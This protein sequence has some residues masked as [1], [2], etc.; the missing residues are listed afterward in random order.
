MS[1]PDDDNVKGSII[2][3]VDLGLQFNEA[4]P[5][6]GEDYETDLQG[7]FT[8]HIDNWS[9]LTADKCISPRFKIGDFDWDILLFPQGNHNKC[10]AVYVEPHPE[11]KSD[12]NIDSDEEDIK[13][14]NT[15]SE[16]V[17]NPNWYACAQFAV[18]ISKPGNDK[19]SH[20]ISRS[21]HR[22]NSADTD[23]GFS[24]LIDLYYLKNT[25]RGRPSGFI[26]DNDLNVTIFV[27]ILKDPTGV[28]WH[29]F[30]NYDSKKETG[31]VG[32]RNQGATCYLN[33]LL[34]SYFFTKYFR[35]L[36]YDIPTNDET[37]NDSVALALQRAFYQ[38]QVSN[39]PLDTLELTRSFGWDTAEAFQQHDVQELNRILMDRLESR[40]KGTSVEGK[41][42]DLFVGKMKSYIKCINV[43]YE[44]SR[45]EDFWD[46]QLNV[47]NMKNLENAFEN[48]I[49]VELMDGENQ[50]AAQNFGLQDAKKGV[51]F[52]SFPEV[53][54]LQ[55]KRFEYDFNY[56]Q[57]IKVNDYYEF[58]DTIDL[59]PYMDKEILSNNPGPNN[60]KLHGVLVHTGDISTG[61]YYAMIKPTTEDK[62]YRFDDEKVWRITKKQVFNENFGL[63]RL[64]DETLS[65][66]A[67][68]DYQE[69]LISRH[70]SAYMLVYIKESAEDKIL[71]TSGESQAP[72]N[73]VTTIQQENVE[74]E[75][76]EKEIREAYLYVTIRIH[77][78]SNFINYQGFDLSPNTHST[79]YSSDLYE[80]DACP[81]EIKVL[82]TTYIKDLRKKINEELK[83]PQGKN[84]RY[85]KMGYRHNSSFRLDKP[86]LSDLELETL[87][88]ALNNKND[89]TLPPLD[90]FVEEP[91]LELSFLN[92]LKS[93]NIYDSCVLNNEL[94]EKI[95]TNISKDVPTD[96]IPEI[97]NIEDYQIIFVK[98]F[99]PFTQKLAGIGHFVAAQLDDI[100]NLS[101]IIRNIYSISD[102]ITFYEECKP[103]RVSKL[104]STGE[105]YKLELTSGDIL[106]FELPN[107]E[108]PNKFPLQKNIDDIYKY[109]RYRIKLKFSKASQS[110]ED[111][112]IETTD[113]K[114]FDIWISALVDYET[115]AKVAAKHLSVEPEYLRLFA[116]Y[117]NGT[118]PMKSKSHLKTYLLKDY[119]CDLIPSVEYEVLSIPL[120]ELEHLMPIKFYWL[121]DSY[122]HFQC[123]DFRVPKHYTVAEFLDRIQK[124][125]KFSDEKKKQIL[126]WTNK[127]CRFEGVLYED[128]TFEEIGKFG[129]LIGRILPEE[130]ALLKQF[131]KEENEDRLGI[132][133]NKT[134]TD[135]NSTDVLMKGSEE[136]PFE[137]EEDIEG[138][139]VLVEQYFKE[140][141]NKHGI[142][143]IFNLIPD[144]NFNDTKARLHAR[145]G[146]GQKEFSKIKLGIHYSTPTGRVFKSLQGFTE[147]ELSKIV[148]YNIMDNF[149]YIYM[150]HPDRLRSHSS[151][152]R[153]MVIKN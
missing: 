99:D 131:K 130:V 79:F 33:S 3:T 103:E 142:S 109:L 67:R 107:R 72:E 74:R 17:V 119:N 110:S 90:I 50:Y 113:P 42:S 7:S 86:I 112:V 82:R 41:L 14:D 43:D 32:F 1:Q 143:F 12:N 105:F 10:L 97:Q 26:S 71:E 83:I 128:D 27:R 36:V 95:R 40:M 38:L 23:W 15:N 69:Y 91:Y 100:S 116:S 56:D 64:P 106:S 127:N 132:P 139:L 13:I 16:D 78:V 120:M 101:K 94:I 151:H 140:Y 19:E 60:Y 138:R 49:E 34:Q 147:A 5:E 96:D 152:D 92:E 37:P 85:W 102:P 144:E 66:M 31:Y 28:L 114:T 108:L 20:L 59:S 134:E 54:H 57:L 9:D 89:E 81:L 84:V 135:S 80:K 73:V 65:K 133:Q 129:Y 125:L 146:L 30:I 137:A 53:L 4:L 25:I 87:E 153:P 48:Y 35:D 126:L 6:L 93:R 24:N 111:Y 122:I 149:D 63:D 150:D 141:D 47:K 55:L 29:N 39:Y 118:Y 11:L 18:A 117:P 44:S 136:N 70:T 22:F 52:E 51:V 145:F 75:K 76:K 2:D 123:H 61:H 58:P 98:V 77:S 21:H 45:V 68:K 124:K 121:S 62:W 88:E 115:L 148:L 46:I 8:W 104:P